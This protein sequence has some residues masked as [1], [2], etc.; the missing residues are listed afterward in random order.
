MDGGGGGLTLDGGKGGLS[1]SL[2]EF[3]DPEEHANES[4]C[5]STMAAEVLQNMCAALGPADADFCCRV[6]RAKRQ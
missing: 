1:L 2:S 4:M 5:V 6:G 3:S